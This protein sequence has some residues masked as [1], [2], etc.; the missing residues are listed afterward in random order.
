MT[1]SMERHAVLSEP[2]PGHGITDAAT[3]GPIASSMPNVSSQ[4]KSLEKLPTC[5]ECAYLARDEIF[6]RHLPYPAGDEFST[7]EVRRYS[8]AGIAVGGTGPSSPSLPVT[9]NPQ[10]RGTDLHSVPDAI[11]TSVQP[12]SCF[13]MRARKIVPHNFSTLIVVSAW[14]HL[15][16][17][18]TSRLA[19]PS[20]P[21]KKRCNTEWCREREF[22]MNIAAV[23]DY[24]IRRLAVLSVTQRRFQGGEENPFPRGC[25]TVPPCIGFLSTVHAPFGLRVRYS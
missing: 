12:T 15:Y 24:E 4:R 3:T 25:A 17:T 14:L 16:Y 8:T 1:E 22:C 2:D 5:H 21:S 13:P 10:G 11:G 9:I 20:L 6:H 18:F 7:A 19:W 23:Y